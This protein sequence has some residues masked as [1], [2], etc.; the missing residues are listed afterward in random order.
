MTSATGQ[1]R[2]EKPGGLL[3]PIAQGLWHDTGLAVAK[4]DV[5]VPCTT[6][7]IE[8]QGPAQYSRDVRVTAIYEGQPNG[9]SG[10]GLVAPQ[11]RRRSRQRN[12]SLDEI[13]KPMPKRRRDVRIWADRPV[14][15]VRDAA[16][17]DRLA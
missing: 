13:S 14:A 15:G 6:G 17:S 16:R 1:S 4:W 7:F 2:M 11:M 9:H 5:Q 8:K 10:N 3:T 12:S